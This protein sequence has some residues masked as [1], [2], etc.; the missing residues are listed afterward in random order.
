MNKFPEIKQSRAAITRF[1]I[2]ELLKNAGYVKKRGKKMT[3]QS[4]KQ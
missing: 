4:N 2:Y 1:I 3:Q